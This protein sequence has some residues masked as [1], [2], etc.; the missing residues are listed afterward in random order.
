VNAAAATAPEPAQGSGKPGKAGLVE[1]IRFVATGSL[2]ALANLAAVWAFQQAVPYAYA[3]VL[4]YIVGMIIAFILFQRVMFN[5]PGLKL[6]RTLLTRRI[7]R[8]TL[9]N[10]VGL[11]LCWLVTMAMFHAIL[12]ALHW[13][14][15][16]DR[17]ANIAG[18]A[19]PAF[20]S[21][22][23]HKFYTYR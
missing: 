19:V 8:F 18:V 11:A 2:A 1:F 3:V 17:I 13:T 4:G 12:P 14:W 6:T 9:V 22:F 23:G 7:V 15:I 16:P 5:T 20:S 10:M 21:Y